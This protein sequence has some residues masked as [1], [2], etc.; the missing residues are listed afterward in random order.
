MARVLDLRTNVAVLSIL[1]PLLAMAS[2]DA[3][4]PPEKRAQSVA[5]PLETVGERT[6]SIPGP[7]L[8]GPPATPT[9][10]GFV[11]VQV[12]I[13]EFGDN[14]LNDAGNEPSIAVDPTAPN[15]IVIGWRQFDNVQSNFRQAGRGY[16][17]DGGRTW[18]FPGV[19]EPGVFRSDPVLDFDA[20]GHF[21]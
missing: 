20:V 12:N 15:R 14:I 19:L 11:S 2:V 5:P 17:H 6:P 9:A 10:G 8:T 7:R 21:Y 1:T 3:S 4:G 18:T 13:D 16:S